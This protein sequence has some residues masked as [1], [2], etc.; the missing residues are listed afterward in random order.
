MRKEGVGAWG[1]WH[2]TATILVVATPPP[3]PGATS[4]RVVDT[5]WATAVHHLLVPLRSC[6][7]AL[8][9]DSCWGAR[10]RAHR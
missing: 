9:A 4:A 7:A 2:L 3:P 8:P 1:V 6:T 5:A 10:R